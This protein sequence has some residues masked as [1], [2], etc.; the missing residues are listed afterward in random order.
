MTQSELNI[1]A[2]AALNEA[3]A[4]ELKKEDPVLEKAEAIIKKNTVKRAEREDT[5]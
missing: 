4:E 1:K 3:V 5:E 2:T